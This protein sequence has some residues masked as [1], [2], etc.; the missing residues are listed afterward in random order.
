MLHMLAA[1]QAW[2]MRATDL[3]MCFPP[4]ILAMAIA[5]ALGV[6]VF[7]AI[8]DAGRVV[9]E[10]RAPGWQPRAHAT[11]PRLCASCA[12]DGLR[13]RPHPVPASAQTR[14]APWWFF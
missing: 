10:I 11:K 9:A 6:G 13:T 3:V 2:I 1:I 14:S 4:I 5:A 8:G 7:N 12:R